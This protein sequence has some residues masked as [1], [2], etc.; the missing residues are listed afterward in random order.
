MHK[1]GMTRPCLRCKHWTDQRRYVI[2]KMI[3][4]WCTRC[5]RITWVELA[6]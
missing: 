4:W 2:D 6:N 3:E 1:E 5:N